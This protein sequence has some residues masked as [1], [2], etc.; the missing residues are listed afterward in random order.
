MVSLTRELTMLR[1]GNYQ[2]YLWD[3]GVT[4]PLRFSRRTSGLE[5]RDG[6]RRSG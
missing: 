1:V 6:R 5:W 2:F 3:D 4:R